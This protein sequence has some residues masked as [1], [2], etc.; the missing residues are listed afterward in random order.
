MLSKSF[1]T[2]QRFLILAIVG[3][4]PMVIM[5]MPFGGFLLF[6]EVAL[7]FYHLGIVFLHLFQNRPGEVKDYNGGILLDAGIRLCHVGFAGA[8]TVKSFLQ[9][10][11]DAVP[12]VFVGIRA[13]SWIYGRVG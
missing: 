11:R 10:C 9:S 2:D 8:S 12:D 1:L 6:Y 13:W 5:N 3:L 7:Y 4:L